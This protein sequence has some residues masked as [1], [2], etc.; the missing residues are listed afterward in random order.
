MA[1]T[2]AQRRAQFCPHAARGT[3][4]RVGNALYAVPH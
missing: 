3:A 4:D 2:I 1:I